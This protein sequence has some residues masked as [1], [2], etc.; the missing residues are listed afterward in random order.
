MM[1]A[2][3]DA[4]RRPR[5]RY[6]RPDVVNPRREWGDHHPRQFWRGCDQARS[7]TIRAS[8]RGVID[9]MQEPARCVRFSLKIWTGLSRDR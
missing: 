1:G 6:G 4:A 5:T 2:R 7:E 3:D 8:A 9:R